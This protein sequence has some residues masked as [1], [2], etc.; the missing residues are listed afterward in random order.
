MGFWDTEALNLA[1][2]AEGLVDIATQSRESPLWLWVE[3]VPLP[4]TRS[5]V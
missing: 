3:R 5:Q 2:D 4:V 1:E